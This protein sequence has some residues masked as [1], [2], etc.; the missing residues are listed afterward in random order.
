MFDPISIFYIAWY[1]N[2]GLPDGRLNVK[3]VI[4]MREN[5]VIVEHISSEIKLRN[6]L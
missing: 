6:G 2:A 1:L 3:E 4:E 5:A